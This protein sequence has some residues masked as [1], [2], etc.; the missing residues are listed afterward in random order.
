[1]RMIQ[2]GAGEFDLVVLDLTLPGVDGLRILTWMRQSV[3]HV[4]G[5][6]LTAKDSM[7]DRVTGLELGADDYLVKLFALSE[8]LARV[9]TLLQRPPQCEPTLQRVGDLELDLAAHK[10]CAGGTTAGPYGAGIRN[11]SAADAQI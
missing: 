5:L 7:E 2:A 8:L 11:A 3:V 6:I 9:R 1:M 10:N 4:P